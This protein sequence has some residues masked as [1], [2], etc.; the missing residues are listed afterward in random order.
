MIGYNPDNHLNLNVIPTLRVCG[1]DTE[2]VENY[3]AA[4]LILRRAPI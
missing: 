3:D 2:Q 1:N 4:H